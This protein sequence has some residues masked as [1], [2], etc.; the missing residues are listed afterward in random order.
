MSESGRKD[1]LMMLGAVLTV[2]LTLTL[3][4]L[5]SS[6]QI[7]R[8]EQGD[9]GTLKALIDVYKETP[10]STPTGVRVAE[11]YAKRYADLGCGE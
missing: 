10:P 11:A 5:T 9:C 3:S 2:A 4:L 8:S 1:G 7:R 6:R